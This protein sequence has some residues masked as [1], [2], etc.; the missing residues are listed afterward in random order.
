MD[1]EVRQWM[2]K[3]VDPSMALEVETHMFKIN[4]LLHQTNENFPADETYAV[5]NLKEERVVVHENRRGE[6]VEV[7]WG[8]RHEWDRGTNVWD[9]QCRGLFVEVCCEEESELSIRAMEQGWMVLRISE[10][11]NVTKD[12]TEKDVAC[13]MRRT[14][15]AGLKVFIHHSFPCTAVCGWSGY[16]IQKN[17]FVA[18]KILLARE[19]LRSMLI[20]WNRFL[21]RFISELTNEE[22]LLITGS[23]EWPNRIPGWD[24]M[25]KEIMQLAKLLRLKWLVEFDGCR[26]GWEFEGTKVKKAMKLL[27]GIVTFRIM[28]HDIYCDNSHEHIA[29]AGR[30]TRFTQNYPTRFC[31]LLVWALDRHFYLPNSWTTDPAVGALSDREQTKEVLKEYAASWE[32][33][34]GRFILESDLRRWSG[35]FE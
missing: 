22:W 27:V 14:I 3:D 10:N 11:H 29:V 32:E 25:Q 17:E 7:H 35:L 8:K 6:C 4:R 24:L 5:Q 12:L 16:N 1:K 33:W 26:L 23:F 18:R 31:K 15:S 28:A 20:K 30:V 19:A 2:T 9:G 13:W 34:P 21:A